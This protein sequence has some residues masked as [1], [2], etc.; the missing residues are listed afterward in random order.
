MIGICRKYVASNSTEICRAC[1][2][3]ITE[4]QA[5]TLIPL[6]PGDNEESRAR[7]AAHVVY[8]SVGAAVHWECCEDSYKKKE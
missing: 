2:K 1:H 7:M 4:G 3:P 8:N 5:F 6:G